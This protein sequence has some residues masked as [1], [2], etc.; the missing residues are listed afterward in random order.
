MFP[1]ANANFIHIFVSQCSVVNKILFKRSAI[2]KDMNIL[3]FCILNYH[4]TLLLFSG[5]H[6]DIMLCPHVT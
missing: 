4:M 3:F 1:H 2:F 6:H 5:E